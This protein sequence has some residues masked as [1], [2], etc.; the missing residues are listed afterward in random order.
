MSL[1]AAD[2][3]QALC[4]QF[5]SLPAIQ[6]LDRRGCSRHCI[7]L[8]QSLPCAG[9]IHLRHAL[10]PVCESSPPRPHGIV[11]ELQLSQASLS[12]SLTLIRDCPGHLLPP[13]WPVFRV[14]AL[15]ALVSS[16]R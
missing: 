1:I 15:S 11:E 2:V 3:G 9:T 10:A 4:V 13:Q 8:F 12:P 5:P 14:L 6:Y 7:I 16:V